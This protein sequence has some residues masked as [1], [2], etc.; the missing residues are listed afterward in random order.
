MR[1]GI[2]NLSGEAA[3]LLSLGIILLAG[4]LSTRV[5]KK[6]RLPQV[7]GYILTGILIGPHLM[8]VIPAAVVNRMGFVSDI[9]LAFIA[10]GVGR[11]FKKETL[12]QTGRAVLLITCLEA[13]LAGVLVF[14]AL[15][16]AMGVEWDL[17]LLL[18]AIATATA[19][20]STVMT[21]H[22]YHAKGRFVDLLLQIVALDDVVCLLVFSGVSAVVTAAGEGGAI[23]FA[24]VALPILYNL[25]AIIL[26]A[27][28]AVILW[29]ILPPSR[30]QDNRLILALAMLLCL[31]GICAIFSVSPLLSCMVFGAV[32]INRTQDERLFEQISAFTPPVMSL[33]FV[34]SGMR[35]DLSILPAFGLVGVVYFL[36]RIAGKYAGAYLGCRMTGQDEKTCRW[37]GG[38][39][40]PQAGVAIG[41]ASLAARM[42]PEQ[43]GNLLLTIILASS[44]LYELVGPVCAKISLVRS[45]AIPPEEKKEPSPAARHCVSH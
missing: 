23:S 25:G 33:F 7:S 29:K 32:Y 28:F 44:V 39:L 17:A 12:R 38:A 20:A 30:S 34:V 8:G 35:L 2:E 26:G 22:Q 18:G 36:V 5:T 42:L 27:V 43:I 4:F 10:F 19:P 1:L 13:L 16:F 11:F 14:C 9:A 3:T 6:L 21:I 24:G 37:L 45:G 31:T 41:L 15:Y 40:V